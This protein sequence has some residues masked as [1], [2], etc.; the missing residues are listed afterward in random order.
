MWESQFACSFC[1]F[2]LLSV[3]LQLFLLPLYVSQFEQTL[4]LSI[5]TFIL[6][7]TIG[8]AF[9][10]SPNIYYNLPLLF[11]YPCRPPPIKEQVFTL[12]GSILSFLWLVLLD[13]DILNKLFSLAL[14]MM[15]CSLWLVFSV[16]HRFDKC[17]RCWWKVGCNF[18]FILNSLENQSR[19]GVFRDQCLT[20]RLELLLER[21]YSE[22]K[23]ELELNTVKLFVFTFTLKS[24]QL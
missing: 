8:L 18:Y 17:C 21:G 13:F 1:F 2:R 4:Q 9:I 22:L 7:L 12:L 6:T 10:L 23:A 11:I 3:I 16:W 19:F 24:S 14:S 20:A 15:E 5:L